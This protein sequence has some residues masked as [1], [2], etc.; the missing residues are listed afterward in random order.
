MESSSHEG[1]T[2]IVRSHTLVGMADD[3]LALLQHSTRLYLVDVTAL[4]HDMFYQQ[5]RAGLGG[6]GGDPCAS[7]GGVGYYTMCLTGGGKRAGMP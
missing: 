7:L 2:D 4:T 3:S 6:A 5:V 1:L